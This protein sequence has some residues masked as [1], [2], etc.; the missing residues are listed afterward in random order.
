MKVLFD[1]N[2]LGNSCPAADMILIGWLDF[3]FYGGICNLSA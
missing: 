2:L 1:T 3:V